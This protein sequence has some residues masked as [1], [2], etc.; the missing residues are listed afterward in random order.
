[1]AKGSIYCL[2][3]GHTLAERMLIFMLE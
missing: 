3:E 2:L 1:M